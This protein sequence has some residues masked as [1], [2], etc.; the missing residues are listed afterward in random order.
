MSKFIKFENDIIYTTKDDVEIGLL[1]YHKPWNQKVLSPAAG[2][3]WSWDCLEAVIYKL[4]PAY[5]PNRIS[6]PDGKAVEVIGTLVDVQS[7]RKNQGIMGK[8]VIA[9]NVKDPNLTSSLVTQQN[10]VVVVKVQDSQI[11]M[12][13]DKTESESQDQ[14]ALEFEEAETVE[15]PALPPWKDDGSLLEHDKVE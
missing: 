2:S 3:I 14:I 1:E 6:D 5:N 13:F 9:F 12:D 10:N 4:N 7:K 11:E 15:A 8:L